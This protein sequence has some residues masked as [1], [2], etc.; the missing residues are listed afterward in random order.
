[1]PST[2][3]HLTQARHN[4][5]FRQSLN[6]TSF[7]DWIVT[8]IFYSAIHYIEAFLATKN[9]HPKNHAYRDNDV[10]IH[11]SGSFRDYRHLKYKSER[12]RYYCQTISLSDVNGCQTRINNIKAS[13][14]MFLPQ[15]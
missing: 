7:A 3:Q 11:M 4:E 10:G 1:M 5:M 12:A 2:D 9:L 6:G 13:L 8:G 15:I 14:R